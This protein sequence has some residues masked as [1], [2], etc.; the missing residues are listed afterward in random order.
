MRRRWGA[1][2]EAV[3]VW[4]VE[5]SPGLA[6][7]ERRGILSL[8]PDVIAFVPSDGSEDVRIPL[9]QVRKARRLR[10][11]KGAGARRLAGALCPSRC[12][13]RSRSDGILLR[14]AA[15]ARGVAWGGYRATGAPG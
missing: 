7:Q 12:G 6:G 8:Q 9:A 4:M 15:A 3:T 10:R 13:W 14:A 5:L 1:M 2:P 11:S